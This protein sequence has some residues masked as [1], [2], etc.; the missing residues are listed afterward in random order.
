MCALPL[1]AR[2]L[3]AVSALSLLWSVDIS[4]T[5]RKDSIYVKRVA[6][7][8]VMLGVGTALA[9]PASAAGTTVYGSAKMTWTVAAS[10]QVALVTDYNTTTV[11]GTTSPTFGV[12]GS[13]SCGAPAGETNNTLTFGSVSPGAVGYTG[14]NYPNAVAVGVNTNDTAGYKVVEYVDSAIPAGTAICAFANGASGANAA[15][16][17]RTGASVP[18]AYAAGACAPGGTAL[19]AITAGLTGT[20]SGAANT[21]AGNGTLNATPAY[22]PY[23]AGGYT[24]ATGTGATTGFAWQGEDVQ[25]NVSFAASTATN[26]TDIVFAVI[27]T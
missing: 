2:A 25:L 8:L 16:T 27:P 21:P 5:L 20:G 3:T 1:T 18:V 10:A 7:A 26:S 4:L 9:A 14:C 6:A 22:T 17:T 11:Q 13:G 19:T 23:T 15:V 24:L 12:N